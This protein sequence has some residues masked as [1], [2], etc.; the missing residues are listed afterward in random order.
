MFES[1]NHAVQSLRDQNDILIEIYCDYASIETAKIDLYQKLQQVY[2]DRFDANQ[3]IVLVL[4]RDWYNQHS[5]AGTLLQTIQIIV[6]DV[7][8]SNFFICI[9]TSNP[10]IESEYLYVKNN[11]SWDT[12]PFEIYPCRGAWTPIKGN[13]RALDG[14]KESLKGVLKVNDMLTDQQQHR[15]F[16]DPVFCMMPWIGINIEPDSKVRPCCEF[17]DNDIGN[18]AENSITEIRNSS[19][20]KKIRLA[21]LQGRAVKGCNSC[22]HKES[23][24]RDSLRN[25]IN[26]DFAYHVSLVDLT[27]ADGSLSSD[28]LLY[29]DVRYNNLCNLACRSCG[30]KSSSSWYQVHNALNPA[31]K[32]IL[33]LLQAG[34]SQDKILAQMSE[35]LSHVEKIYFAGGEPMIIE[36]FYT[37]LELLDA[38][39]RNEV[40]ICYNT[41]LTKLSLKQHSILDLWKRF[42]NVSVG[43]SLDAMGTRAEYLRSGTKWDDVVENRKLILKQCPHVDFYVSATTGLINALHVVDFHRH[44]IDQNIIAPEDFNVQLLFNPSYMSVMNAPKK[45]KQKIVEKYTEHINWLRPYD[46]I[47]RATSGFRSMID[48]AQAPD[49]YNAEIF[50]QEV[51]KL[52]GYHN[53]DLFDAFPELVDCGL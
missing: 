1:I 43:A 22:Y 21:M 28:R 5:L 53:T 10:D 47:G 46:Q 6:Q 7:D 36:N 27:Q 49:L 40:Q 13:Y 26:R 14:K 51:K 24:Q 29:W 42:P 31:D 23:L 35:H 50:W 9:V 41:N 33:P 32:Q 25:S 19:S 48:L 30:P 17:Q 52:D 12:V 45:L 2:R 4:D 3:R 11:I 8:I 18:A 44:W 37:I 15:L 34:Q 39:G 20:W 16:V 38:A